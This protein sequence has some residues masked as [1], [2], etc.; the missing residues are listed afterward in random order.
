MILK[1]GSTVLLRWQSSNP[2]KEEASR[3]MRFINSL[4]KDKEYI[5][6]DKQ[7][8]LKAEKKWV[9]E[10]CER[11][12]NNE[13]LRLIAEKDKNIIGICDAA[14]GKWKEKGNV[15]LGVSVAKEFRGKGL[16]TALLR[17]IIKEAKRK[18][19]PEN[20]VLA[21]IE[22]NDPAKRLYE[23]LG[24]RKFAV[25]PRWVKHRGRYK[26]VIWMRL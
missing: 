8:P 19:K 22:G 10:G 5:L 15:T 21:Y 1:D 25:F 14:R 2:K 12:R 24:F 23:K 17:I 6:M 7:T 16:G 20:I 18:W 26:N 13:L 3:F 4:V 9:K 11:I